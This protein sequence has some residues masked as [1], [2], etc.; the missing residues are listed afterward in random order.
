MLQ[1]LMGEGT[2]GA[3]GGAP[4]GGVEIFGVPG[5]QIRA[6]VVRAEFQI[7]DGQAHLQEHGFVESLDFPDLRRQGRT[8]GPC[9]VRGSAPNVPCGLS[10]FPYFLAMLQNTRPGRSAAAD[11]VAALR[12]LRFAQVLDY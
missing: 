12:N 3:F 9:L 4:E 2:A 1:L 6:F 10:A 11:F 7:G 8:F 5:I